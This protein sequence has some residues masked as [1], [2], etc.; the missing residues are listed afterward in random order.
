MSKDK[1]RTFKLS[2]V[3][4]RVIRP[5]IGIMQMPHAKVALVPG[6]FESPVSSTQ[7][8][9][10]YSLQMGVYSIYDTSN[11][12]QSYHVWIH[13]QPCEVDGTRIGLANVTQE[14]VIEFLQEKKREKE[15]KKGKTYILTDPSLHELVKQMRSE[16]ATLEEIRGVLGEDVIKLNDDDD[17]DYCPM[18]ASYVCHCAKV[19]RLQETLGRLVLTMNQTLDFLQALIQTTDAELVGT[20]PGKIAEVRESDQS[21][22]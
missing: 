16:G 5:V 6:P 18:D 12:D 2:M 7:D 4:A 17:D 3:H 21:H 13:E 22:S 9:K 14:W 19:N 11:P 1:V 10:I 8:Y 20:L 15:K